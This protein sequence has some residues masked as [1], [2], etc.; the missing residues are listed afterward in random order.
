VAPQDS[1]AGKASSGLIF[2][3]GPFAPSSPRSG[4]TPPEPLSSPGFGFGLLGLGA[5]FG[6]GGF[7][8]TGCSPAAGGA[9]CEV[10]G[11]GG[12]VAVVGGGSGR[13][14]ATAPWLRWP[15]PPWWPRLRS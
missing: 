14:C 10:G 15:H 5:G 4:L 11:G 12:A 7:G 9:G 3:S 13:S 6:F 8:L 1:G 2:A